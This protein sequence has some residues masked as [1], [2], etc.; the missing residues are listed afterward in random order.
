MKR[1]YVKPELEVV[2]FD[3][4]SQILSASS[5]GDQQPVIPGEGGSNDFDGSNKR[6]NAWNSNNWD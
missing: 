2:M 4:E 6:Q 1:I 5:G 3:L